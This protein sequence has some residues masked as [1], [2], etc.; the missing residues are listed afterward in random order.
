DAV[1]LHPVAHVLRVR[2]RGG[3]DGVDVVLAGGL[4]GREIALAHGPPNRRSSISPGSDIEKAVLRGCRPVAR[5]DRYDWGDFPAGR[6]RPAC[7]AP[8]THDRKA[9]S[10][11]QT[12]SAARPPAPSS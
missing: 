8:A 10:P 11:W 2:L 5:G 3:G 9:P 1:D 12:S 7:R 4:A 6:R